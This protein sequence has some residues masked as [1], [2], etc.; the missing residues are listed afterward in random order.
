MKR[1]YQYEHTTTS[2]GAPEGRYRKNDAGDIL[3]VLALDDENSTLTIRAIFE[4]V[5]T[6]RMY[7][8]SYEALR[9]FEICNLEDAAS[10]ELAI[11]KRMFGKVPNALS[12]NEVCIFFY[13]SL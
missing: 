10:F 8:D 1:L 3:V 11:E 12:I 4:T 9:L 6:R 2:T 7:S 13:F 5:M